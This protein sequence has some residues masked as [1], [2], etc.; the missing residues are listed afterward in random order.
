M[1]DHI[2]TFNNFLRNDLNSAQQEAVQHRDGSL[3]IVAGA[4]S[5]KTRVITARIANLILN[6]HIDPSSIIALTFTNKAAKEMQERIRFFLGGDTAIPFIGTF[7]AY[8]L[9]ILKN[10]AHLLPTPFISILDSDDQQKML[11]GII[12]R[13]HL[14]KQTTAQQLGYQISQIKNQTHNPD[15]MAYSWGQNPLIK[16]LFAAYEEEKRASKCL[17]FDDLLLET[18]RLFK[19]NP[20]LPD[21]THFMQR[22]HNSIAHILVDEYQ[23]TNVVQHELLTAM[24]KQNKQR[25]VDSICVVGDEDQ[26]IYSWRGATVANI[27]NFKKDFDNTTVIKLEQNYRSVQPILEIANQIIKHNKNRNPKKL[28]SERTGSDRIRRIICASDYQESETIAHFLTC[29]GRTQKLNTIAIL[30]RTHFQ[31]RS[32]EEGLIRYSIPY[33]IVGGIQFYERKE[34]KDLLAYLR[35]IV[36]PFDRT[37]FFRVI[38]CPAR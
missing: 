3:L 2:I 34:V 4:G 26:S 8:C 32:L 33:K 18:L 23:D 16:Q 36:N 15:Q 11:H 17:D 22:F 27:M 31:S 29:A 14:N 35:L 28:W 20:Q 21:G 19:R 37:S 24:A 25:V 30:Y 7:H 1:N 12:T 5:G 38:N 9:R 6:E 10:N 13:H